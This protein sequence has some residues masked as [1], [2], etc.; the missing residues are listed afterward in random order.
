MKPIL[1]R[2]SLAALAAPF[3][4][5]ALA[6]DAGA[7]IPLRVVTLGINVAT[8]K[9]SGDAWDAFGG[10]P[11]IAIC[12]NSALG[13]RCY[14]AGNGAYASPSAFGRSR[15]PDAF[16]CTFVVG[17][18]STGPFSLS[19]YDVDLSAHDLIGSCA[20]TPNGTISVGA[21]GSATLAV[22]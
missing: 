13:Q 16:A 9:P 10:A 7:Q 17:V 1:R 18:P 8:H 12:I 21:C 6:S 4:C 15:C 14:A 5:G 22:R 11:D 2:A 3:V 19:I 20:V